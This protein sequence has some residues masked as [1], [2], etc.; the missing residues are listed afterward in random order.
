MQQAS[1]AQA[2]EPVLAC[3]RAP[4]AALVCVRALC[5]RRLP[6]DGHSAAMHARTGPDTAPSLPPLH[7]LV[8]W[9]RSSVAAPLSAAQAA[10]T[11]P[12]SRSVARVGGE[13]PG[14]S[15]PFMDIRGIANCPERNFFTSARRQA[16]AKQAFRVQM[17]TTRVSYKH[18]FRNTEMKLLNYDLAS[19]P[20]GARLSSRGSAP[21]LRRRSAPRLGVRAPAAMGVRAPAPLGVRAQDLGNL[22]CSM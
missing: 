11:G 15:Q 12:R 9:A 10:A 17:F 8:A 14:S 6:Q 2:S 19:A 18:N 3:L 1:G 20:A 4:A 22:E 5:A 7:L 21:H 13:A 16:L